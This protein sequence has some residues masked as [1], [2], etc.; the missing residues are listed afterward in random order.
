LKE[1]KSQEQCVK[2]GRADIARPAKT[3]YEEYE[4]KIAIIVVLES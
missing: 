3:K 1:L 2:W 4:A